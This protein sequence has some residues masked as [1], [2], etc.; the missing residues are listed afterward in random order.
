MFSR[1]LAGF[2][3][4][5]SLFADAA[6]HHGFAL[7]SPHPAD[8]PASALGPPPEQQ[9]EW[10]PLQL[11][12]QDNDLEIEREKMRHEG[13]M[14]ILKWQLENGGL[15]RL[16][17][18]RQGGMRGGTISGSKRVATGLPEDGIEAQAEIEFNQ[19]QFEEATC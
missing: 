2:S 1:D 13:E 3:G 10:M 6:G 5:M 18:E 17:R 16:L 12:K 15:S 14:L 4:D 7:D 8:P 9:S 11:R 19:L